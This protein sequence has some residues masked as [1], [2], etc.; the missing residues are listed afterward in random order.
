MSGDMAMDYQ[1]DVFVSYRRNS[2]SLKWIE[3]EFLPELVP[4]LELELGREPKVFWDEASVDDGQVI[5]TRIL[6]ALRDSRCLLS[7]LS[8]PYFTSIWCSAE[9]HTFRER[10]E[11]AGLL[12]NA[13]T[14]TIPIQWHDGDN[15][16]DLLQGGRGPH[17]LNFSRF[18][19]NGAWRGTPVHVEFQNELNGLADSIRRLIEGTPPYDPAGV[20]VRPEQ[21]TRTQ[22]SPGE[23]TYKLGGLPR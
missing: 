3:E 22:L 5:Q 1:Y 4:R 18:R 19:L 2:F 15:Y 9:W 13:R 11:R 23:W 8:G 7:L 17:T 21:V 14:L 10:A 16:L 20:I 12:A 6:D